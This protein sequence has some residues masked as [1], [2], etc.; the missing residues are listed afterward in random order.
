VI[1]EKDFSKSYLL[2]ESITINN[3]EFW[4]LVINPECQIKHPDIT[5]E[6]ILE[7]AK[8]LNSKEFTNGKI[9]D[10]WIYLAKEPLFD[11]KN[12][13]A[14]RLIWCWP[15]NNPPFFGIQ[16]CFK[17]GKHEQQKKNKFKIQIN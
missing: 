8:Q 2:N 14:H 15:I 17:I 12:K 6:I 13:R 9:S 3:I 10:N 4:K 7:L 16:N 5:D 1:K 11:D